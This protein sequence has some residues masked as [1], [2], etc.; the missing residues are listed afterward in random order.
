MERHK[1]SPQ[2]TAESSTEV[3]EDTAILDSFNT[4]ID[5]DKTEDDIKMSMVGAG[6]TFKNVTRL[7]NDYLVQTGRAM[8]KESK[9]E[10]VEKSAKDKDL[11]DEK[12]FGKVVAKIVEAGTNV[13]EGSAASLVRAWAKKAEVECY[14]KPKGSGAT[15]NPFVQNFHAALI[16]NPAMDEDGLKKVIADLPEDNRVNPTRWFNQH[17]A[18]RKMVNQIAAG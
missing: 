4:A 13:S 12:T 16:A 7:Y 11:A 17:N 10:L 2:D 18:I 6:A 9:S 14:A 8:T 3:K 5:A 15:R 1:M